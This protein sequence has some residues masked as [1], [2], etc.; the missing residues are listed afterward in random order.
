MHPQSLCKGNYRHQQEFSA[1]DLQTKDRV[2]IPVSFLHASNINGED[3]VRFPVLSPVKSYKQAKGCMVW[4]TSVE[5]A[6]VLWG[7]EDELE[8]S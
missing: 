6:V 1:S 5:K 2:L 4:R 8:G 3:T 7:G